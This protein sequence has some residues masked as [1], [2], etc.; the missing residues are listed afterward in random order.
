MLG[1]GGGS[2]NVIGFRVPLSKPSF[3]L[4]AVSL[5]GLAFLNTWDFPFYIVLFCGAY[6]VS[7]YFRE[8]WS[9]RRI[10][11]FIYLALILGI[12]SV[13]IYLPFYV[14]FQSQ[15]GGV[16]PSL[17]YFTRGTY[18]WVMFAPLL[19]PIFAFIFYLWK[20]KKDKAIIRRTIDLVA[21]L[22]FGLWGLSYLFGYAIS[23]LPNLGNLFM[24]VQEGIDAPFTPISTL[25]T[26]AF[27]DRLLAP[28]TWI[29]LGVLLNFCS[30]TFTKE[31]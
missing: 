6:A 29:T 3:L 30:C 1:G 16:L 8:G 7:Q 15:A 12:T 21:I 13:V 11:E 17:I 10:G 25:L 5:G 4:T 27:V 14:G 22:I 20:Q 28:G 31:S 23:L 9:L 18:F 2:F 26:T 19:I 24:S